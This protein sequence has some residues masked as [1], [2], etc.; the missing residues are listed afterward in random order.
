MANYLNPKTQQFIIDNNIVV[1]EAVNSYDPQ[2]K[3]HGSWKTPAIRKLLS[4]IRE[5]G[6]YSKST[7]DQDIFSRVVDHAHK[8]LRAAGKI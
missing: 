6:I 1:L 5:Q 4:I 3:G 8:I 2:S 7:I